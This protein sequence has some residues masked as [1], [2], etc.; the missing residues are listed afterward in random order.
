MKKRKLIVGDKVVKIWS[1]WSSTN[2]DFT[3]VVRL[4]NTT[5]ILA[6]G[7]KL[8][9]ESEN[10]GWFSDSEYIDSFKVIGGGYGERYQF[11]TPEILAEFKEQNRKIKIENW[12]YKFKDKATL[13][14]KEQIYNLFNP[15][16]NEK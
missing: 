11:E 4:T 2:Y 5:A 15:E 7:K 16:I 12:F 13:E 1:H 8:K 14:Q 6:N 10:L 3:T 9:N